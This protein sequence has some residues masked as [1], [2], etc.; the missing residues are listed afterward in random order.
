[1]AQ[2]IRKWEEWLTLVGETARVIS[3]A[4]YYTRRPLFTSLQIRNSAEE[5]AQ[6][7]TLTLTNENGM[8]IPFEKVIENIPF[9]SV[10]SVE[11]GNILSPA[12]FAGTTE[13]REEKIV[14]VL[15]KDKKVLTTAEWTV[16]ALPFD[17]WQGTDGD[18]ALLSTFVRPRLADYGKV[19]NE[20]VAQLKK[21]DVSCDL[22]GYVGNDKNT[23][24]RI[25]ASVYASIRKFGIEKKETD[26]SV[27]V[28][29]G[30]SAHILSTQKAS[31]L[32]MALFV[33]GCLESFGLH[34]VLV[35]GDKEITCGVWL[36]DSC[37]M[38]TVS[39]DTARLLAYV[40][41]GINNISCFDV[42]DLFSDR[43][44]SYATSE[45]HF[46]Q[47]VENGTYYERIV[48]VR[49]CRLSHILPLP[50]RVQGIK[51]YEVLT[52]EGSSPDEMPTKLFDRDS[53][54][55]KT[56]QTK[57]KQWE[58][59]LLDLSMKNTLL[60]FQ[61]GKSVVHL[62]TGDLDETLALFAGNN[63]TY[64]LS[65]G[66]E[67]NKL[68]EKVKF[69]ATTKTRSMRELIEV[70]NRSGIVRAYTDET[71]LTETVGKLMRKNKEAYEE[72][73]TKIL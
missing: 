21:W 35:F 37:F 9:E 64:I 39:D 50:M 32:E 45:L 60:H 24:R 71:T 8:L 66:D 11:T 19:R 1:M 59:R 53:L 26:I 29:A 2:K 55:L 40:S 56:E 70:E 72:S 33:S 28:E 38:D 22:S 27:P 73:G 17:Y 6:G 30:T 41:D 65:A 44:A 46:R 3:Y 62:A 52:E 42:E 10:V 58:R 23:V 20:V 15:K 54:Q 34:P 31:A 5:E 68:S 7:L 12:Y 13:I 49:R 43:N 16:T 36:Y 63:E 25:V 48:D 47:K 69:G 61:A 67:L 18:V 51:G 57:D 4:D 14:A